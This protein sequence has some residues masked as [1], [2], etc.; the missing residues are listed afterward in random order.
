MK[1]L[2]SLLTVFPMV[3]VFLLTGAMAK[4]DTLSLTLSSP[5]QSSFAGNVLTFDATVTN[6]T[7]T[8]SIRPPHS[9]VST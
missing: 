8:S 5:F 3:V 9:E 7:I 2:R 1:S 4:A 6:D